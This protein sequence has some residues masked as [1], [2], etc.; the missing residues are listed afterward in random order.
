MSQ[1]ALIGFI[2]VLGFSEL[3]KRKDFGDL[4]EQYIQL[5]R[6]ALNARGQTHMEYVVFSDS[7]V[8]VSEKTDYKSLFL[9]IEAVSLFSFEAL[10]KLGLPIKGS[11]TS[12]NITYKKQ[13]GDVVIAGTPI[14]EAYKLEQS[15]NWVGAMISPNTIREYEHFFDL[16]DYPNLQVPI[17]LERLK[18]NM[19][20]AIT[21]QKTGLI[22][23]KNKSDDD[24][25]EGY[26]IVPRRLSSVD[27]GHLK[28]DMNEYLDALTKEKFFS[29]SPD[30]QRKYRNTE[31]F[32]QQ[33]ISLW[34]K[35]WASNTYRMHF[36]S[37][38]EA[39]N[40]TDA[41]YAIFAPDAPLD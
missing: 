21:V 34:H 37:K 33:V 12:G 4:F 9:L 30:V 18:K 1:K 17:Q 7:I 3:V 40:R 39:R 19:A 2:D 10:T 23:Y 26:A 24:F 36:W 41:G 15:Q 11:I 32:V 20:W 25:F 38:N 31:Q 8:I 22:P 16:V 28:E 13:D 27:A 6:N 35:R 29:A 5:I 14:V